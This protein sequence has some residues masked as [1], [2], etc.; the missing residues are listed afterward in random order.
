MKAL[1][2]EGDTITEKDISSLDT[3][4]GVVQIT[5]KSHNK[6]FIKGKRVVLQG[7]DVQGNHAISLGTTHSAK[8]F[9]NGK[10]VL[11]IGDTG[12]DAGGHPLSP[13]QGN[14]Q[15]VVFEGS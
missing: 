11:R 4:A 8:I 10:A 6:F 13:I 9:V 12:S 15:N 1:A 14:S 2:V 5:V 7:E 3:G